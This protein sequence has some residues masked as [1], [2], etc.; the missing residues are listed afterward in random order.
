MVSMN[1]NIC[2]T[3]VKK[4]SVVRRIAILYESAWPDMF[5]INQVKF[6]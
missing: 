3:F 4:Y 2:L 5:F 6:I 1:E